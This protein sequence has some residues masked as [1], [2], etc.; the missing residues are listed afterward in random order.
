MKEIT[1]KWAIIT[2]TALAL[3]MAAAGIAGAGP[4]TY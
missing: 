2:A 4:R 3:D 1:M